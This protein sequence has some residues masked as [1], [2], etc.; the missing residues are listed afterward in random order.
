MDVATMLGWSA[1]RWP[2]R[3]AVG[4]PEPL[5]YAPWDDRTDRLARA[6][7]SV[8]VGPW[9][10]SPGPLWAAQ[11]GPG[12]GGCSDEVGP[13]ARKG[14]SGP[15]E[16]GNEGGCQRSADSTSGRPGDGR[17]SCQSLH[18]HR[19]SP[20]EAGGGDHLVASAVGS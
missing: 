7:L 17:R 12:R 5:T 3:R 19:G 16:D 6:L 20:G 14:P 2:H 1:E 4:G 18:R 15:R 13:S 9:T 11:D 10:A 8:G